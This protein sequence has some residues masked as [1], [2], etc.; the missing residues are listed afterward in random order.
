M[1]SHSVATPAIEIATRLDPPPLD[2]L[3]LQDPAQMRVFVDETDGLLQLRFDMATVQS[4]MRVADPIALELEYTRVMMRCLLFNAAPKSMLMIGL[5]GGSLARYCHHTMPQTDI[6][7]VEINPHVIALR[8]R[9]QVPPDGPRFRVLQADGAA[10]IRATAQRDGEYGP[11][12][13]DV[14]LIDAFHFDGAPAGI[15]SRAFFQACRKLL[16]SHGVLVMN[17]ES[18]PELCQPA[19][20]NLSRA[21]DGALWSVPCDATNNRIA[22]AASK[23][24]LM[25][26]MRQADARLAAL[27]PIHRDTLTRRD[28]G[29]LVFGTLFG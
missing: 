14:L 29:R 24:H 1:Q 8:E 5:G 12:Q 26:T 7:A 23:D 21:F 13:L 16:S 10:F 4:A 25:A 3:P 22:F 19:L 6:T 11:G 28:D 27:A 2:F 17:L 20:H 9:F 18:E 15:N